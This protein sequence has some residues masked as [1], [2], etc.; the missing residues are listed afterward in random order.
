M[1]GELALAG[2]GGAGL[3]DG[4]ERGARGAH[5]RCAAHRGDGRILPAAQL[6]AGDAGVAASTATAALE[7]LL[8]RGAQLLERPPIAGRGSQRDVQGAAQGQRQVPARAPQQRKRPAD[9]PHG[10]GR[11]R[12]RERG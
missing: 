7:R 5:G 1:L 6:R 9:A 10:G 2:P 3:A 11:R 12:C 8:E 4:G